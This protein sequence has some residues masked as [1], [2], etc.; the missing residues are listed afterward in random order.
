MYGPYCQALEDMLSTNLES[1]GT[2]SANGA[3]KDNVVWIVL[4]RAFVVPSRLLRKKLHP[5][6]LVVGPETSP[7]CQVWLLMG[8]S[9]AVPGTSLVSSPS[10]S[11]IDDASL[12][13][14]PSP[15]PSP[16]DNVSIVSDVQPSSPSSNLSISSTSSTQAPVICSSNTEKICK[17]TTADQSS[18][19]EC[20]PAACVHS[21]K[22]K[23]AYILKPLSAGVA[24]C[25]ISTAAV[26]VEVVKMGELTKNGKITFDIL[27]IAD[28][29]CTEPS[30][31]Q[32][33]MMVKVFHNDGMD[34]LEDG[35]PQVGQVL[36]FKDMMVSLRQYKT[37]F[38][39]GFHK[40]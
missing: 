28:K 5:F 18:D 32:T 6:S 25:R 22:S 20:A 10:S 21:M 8:S 23:R 37:F 14:S 29:T 40:W 7:D 16:S 3:K 36:V 15:S 35:K 13:P 11:V 17:A 39:F 12:P 31:V 34:W 38:Y 1:Q 9:S 33:H 26:L 4:H 2:W 24:D 27:K 19:P 30:A